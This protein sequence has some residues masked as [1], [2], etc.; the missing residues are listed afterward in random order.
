MSFDKYVVISNVEHH[1][2]KDPSL[3][4]VIKP[5]TI[6]EEI[7]LS[8]FYQEGRLK[9]VDG[10]RITYPWSSIEIA[11]RQVALLF[12]GT[13]VTKD[14]TDSLVLR[15]DASLDAIEKYLGSLPP[16]VVMELFTAIGD[17]VPSWG[18]PSPKKDEETKN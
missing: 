18:K 14:G 10:Q 11:I 5:P 12:G 7:A 4:W 15:D 2:E 8:R 9:I 13:N 6:K 17:A 3:F 16:S 1:F